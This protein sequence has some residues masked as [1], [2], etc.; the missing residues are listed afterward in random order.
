MKEEAKILFVHPP[1]NEQAKTVV[2]TLQQ[3]ISEWNIK[4]TGARLTTLLFETRKFDIAHF[5]LPAA[6]K[7]AQ[8]LTKLKGKTRFVQTILSSPQKPEQYKDVIFGDQVIVFSER[9]KTE[10]QEHAPDVPAAA[11]PPCLLLPEATSLQGSSRMREN[12]NTGERLLAVALNDFADRKHF[13]MFLYIAREYQR[14]EGFR[15]LIPCIRKD[16]E[17]LA[18]RSRLQASL[19]QEKLESTALLDDNVD[20]HSLIDGCDITLYV[21]QDRE[22]QFEFPLLVVEALAWGKPVLCSGG[23]PVSDTVREFRSSW[24]ASDAEDFVRISRDVL[25]EAGQLEQISTELAR[26]A[27]PR[28]SV[29]SVAGAYRSLYHHLLHSERVI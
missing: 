27:R 26:F 22:L 9:Q 10:L 29:Q 4:V 17:A 1:E 3:G 15:F 25:K 28:F 13:N 14:R 8:L 16:K 21:K 24:I 7:T 11:I 20:L 12:F 18:W 6:K 5:F 23:G 2:H 19:E